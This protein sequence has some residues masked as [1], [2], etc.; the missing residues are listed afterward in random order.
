M[1]EEADPFAQL[2][3]LAE[4]ERERARNARDR[5]QEEG[6]AVARRAADDRAVH[7]L[8]RDVNERAVA[9]HEH[10]AAVFEEALRLRHAGPRATS[11]GSASRRPR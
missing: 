9:L 2:A 4:R 6:A 1:A 7:E 5:A 3:V 8:A 10:A 11:D